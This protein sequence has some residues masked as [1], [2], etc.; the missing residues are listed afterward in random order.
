MGALQFA[1]P[2]TGDF[3][4][5]A[6]V[7]NNGSPAD[8]LEAST[9]FFVEG[10]LWVQAANLLD[11]DARVTVY[12]DQHGGQ[13]DDPIG[14]VMI[15]LT[16]DIPSTSPA[17]WRV[18]VPA[19]TLPNAPAGGSGIYELSVLLEVFNSGGTL[20]GVSAFEHLPAAYRIS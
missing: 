18:R 20:L 3:D 11:G 7:D 2:F 15:P 9:D 14:T 10:T 8:I 16:G 5:T 12:A 17:Q 19:G 4:V 1:P 13:F 6:V